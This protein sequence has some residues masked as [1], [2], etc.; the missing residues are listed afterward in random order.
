[1]TSEKE[2]EYFNVGNYVDD[3]AN[4]RNVHC[5]TNQSE[6]N[7]ID[8]QLLREHRSR[9]KSGQSISYIYDGKW[10]DKHKVYLSEDVIA[11][12]IN[13]KVRAAKVT[14]AINNDRYYNYLYKSAQRY[15]CDM[16]MFNGF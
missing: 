3:F 1:M 13:M 5:M 9:A 15:G 8:N 11:E 2:L 4:Y 14:G 7:K 10:A 12:R 6:H 16:R